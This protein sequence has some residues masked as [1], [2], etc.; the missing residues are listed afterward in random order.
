VVDLEG[1]DRGAQTAVLA[2]ARGF[3]GAYGV[4]AYVAVLLGRPAVVFGAEGAD[5]TD[6]RIASTFLARAPFGRLET[7]E[8]GEPA[9]RALALL[10]RQ[11]ES[12]AGVGG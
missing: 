2:R 7:I 6:L 8:A 9:E 12:L 4:E 1:L 5:P 11:A 10:E 3:V